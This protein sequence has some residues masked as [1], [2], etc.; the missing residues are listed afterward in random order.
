MYTFSLWVL[1][2]P[3]LIL[4]FS[5]VIFL[6]CLLQS[7]MKSLHF[8]IIIV[9][10]HDAIDFNPDI[11]V[12]P[13]VVFQSFG[14]EPSFYFFEFFLS[15]FLSYSETFLTISCRTVVKRDMP[16]LCSLRIRFMALNF[17]VFINVGQHIF[18]IRTII[19]LYSMIYV[20]FTRKSRSFLIT[21][22]ILDGNKILLNIH[23]AL[24]VRIHLLKI[25]IMTIF[26]I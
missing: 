23:R 19:R 16:R 4:N 22:Y 7:I 15:F 18:T 11:I 5:Y 1:F 26:G 14:F 3:F 21:N 13:Q 2:S 12:L 25:A 8:F 20:G 17:N 10:V 9:L 6:F 24:I